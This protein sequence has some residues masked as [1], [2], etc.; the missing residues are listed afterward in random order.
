MKY[1]VLVCAFSVM[2]GGK[3]LTI[4]LILVPPGMGVPTVTAARILKGQLSGQSG[5]ETQLEMDKF[6]F[7]SLAKVCHVFSCQTVALGAPVLSVRV[8]VRSSLVVTSRATYTCTVGQMWPAGQSL[9]PVHQQSPSTADVCSSSPCVQTYNTNAQ[10]ADSA[11]T[12]TAFLCGVKANEGTVGVS[13]AAVRS[14]CNSTKG[15]EVTSILKWA[16]DAGR[17]L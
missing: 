16:K 17:S 14:Q 8:G 9:T 1:H 11:G 12:A 2:R 13:A 7:V 15:N 3:S 10:V 4:D 5:E 6:P